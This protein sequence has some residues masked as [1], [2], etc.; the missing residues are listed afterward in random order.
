ME[1][2]LVAELARRHGLGP[3]VGIGS[4][5]AASGVARETRR[6]LRRALK[7]VVRQL[8]FVS[9]GKAR[10]AD[11]VLRLT[12]GV[13]A[14]A[15]RR[16]A[17]TMAKALD[18]FAGRP[19]EVALPLC[20]WKRG[21]PPP[22]DTA[23]DPARD[24]C[25]LIWY[26]PLVVADP[27]TV[28]RYNRFVEQTCVEHGIEP[29][30]TLTSLSPQCFDSTVPLLFQSSDAEQTQRAHA[31]YEALLERGRSLGFMPYRLPT[32]WM[33]RVVSPEHACWRTVSE[34]KAAL[35]PNDVIAPGR[36]SP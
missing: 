20:Y 4:I 31:C 19:S 24:G 30:I 3:W 33:N 11:R 34:L 32:A 9:P 17:G 15:M 7:P 10:L 35:D 29:L 2:H 8:R 25:G 23:I 6:H 18:N 28:R 13:K 27:A 14:A 5:Y 36:Y 16:R 22:T 12:P 1:P 21:A 26:S